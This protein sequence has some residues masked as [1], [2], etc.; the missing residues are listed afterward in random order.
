[1]IDQRV[2]NQ[3]W[4]AFM[5]VFRSEFNDFLYFFFNS[6]IFTALSSLFLSS[7]INQL[8]IGVLNNMQIAFPKN[9]EERKSIIEFLT[10]SNKK[11]NSSINL[12]EIQL[13]K[14]KSYRQSIISE[15][16]TGKID[17]RDWQPKNK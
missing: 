10:I 6:D 9:E 12:I 2:E 7:T 1:M 5:T 15:A 3:T 16:V 13:E 17:V 8:T 14:L 4:G 11:I